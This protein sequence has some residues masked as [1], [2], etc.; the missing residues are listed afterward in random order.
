MTS[1]RHRR[2]V[3]PAL[4]VLKVWYIPRDTPHGAANVGRT[5]FDVIVVT[6]K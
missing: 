4:V 1:R 3:C 2:L 5:S 6:L